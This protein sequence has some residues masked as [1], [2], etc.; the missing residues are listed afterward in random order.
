[1]I[2]CVWEQCEEQGETEMGLIGIV[3]LKNP[4]RVLTE[5]MKKGNCCIIQRKGT[6]AYVCR[7]CLVFLSK[8]VSEWEGSQEIVFRFLRLC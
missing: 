8:R 3:G 5:A 4:I 6:T 7:I 1:M 2:I